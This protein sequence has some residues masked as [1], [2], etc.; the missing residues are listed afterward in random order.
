MDKFVLLDVNLQVL[1]VVGVKLV[2]GDLAIQMVKYEEMLT[3]L[4]ELKESI[5]HSLD[6][7]LEYFL[8]SRALSMKHS[9]IDTIFGFFMVNLVRSI[10]SVVANHVI[11]VFRVNEPHQLE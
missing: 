10:D 7:K 9:K 11:K 5:F 3:I 2:N 6:R 4:R 8:E 1:I